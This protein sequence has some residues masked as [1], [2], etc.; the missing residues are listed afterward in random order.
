MPD[1]RYTLGYAEE[2]IRFLDRRSLDSHG[3]FFAPLLLAGMD[4]LDCGCGPGG[5][6]RGI[7]ARV[8]PG[9]VTGIDMDATQVELATRR[10]AQAGVGNV[11]FRTASVYEL[12]FPDASFDAI[13]SHAL[14]EHLADKPRAA[15]ECLRVLRPGGVIGVCTPDWGGFIVAPESDE[16]RAAIQA[17]EDAQNRNGGDTRT[18]RKLATL[19]RE[20][21]FEGAKPAARYENFSPLSDIGEVLASR[22]DRDGLPRLAAVLRAWQQD[23]HG[24][25]SEAWVSCIAR[26]PA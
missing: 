21:G 14:F 13:F 15:R 10:A 9:R 17:Y 4:V 23:P 26:K 19:L 8:A 25:F 20:A 2:A 6:T 18:G 1:E 11:E 16:L 22:L 3:A 5:I 12:P 24:L 7:A